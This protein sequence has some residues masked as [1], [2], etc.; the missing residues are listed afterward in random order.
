[1]LDAI[2]GAVIVVVATSALV[3]AVEVAEQSLDSAGR[4]PLNAAERELLQQAGR[5]DA[6]SLNKL[7]ADLNSLPRQ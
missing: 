4:Q 3:L 5:S 7:Q 1:M 6:E 2:V